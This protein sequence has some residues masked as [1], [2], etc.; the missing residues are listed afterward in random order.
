MQQELFDMEVE[1][2]VSNIDP[3]FS[4]VAD[5]DKVDND[6]K[7]GDAVSG[8]GGS[9]VD[10]AND[11]NRKRM[12]AV[13]VYT[14]QRS[15][16]WQLRQGSRKLNDSLVVTFSQ[17]IAYRV[18]DAAYVVPDLESIVKEPF[19]NISKRIKY[20][21][22][23]KAQGNGTFNDLKR[24]TLPVIQKDDPNPGDSPK[25]LD[26]LMIVISVLGGILV[27]F[28]AGLIFLRSK[29]QKISRF[30]HPQIDLPDVPDSGTL[31]TDPNGG[32]MSP[33]S[34]ADYPGG[35][36]SVVTIDH[37]Y[38]GQYNPGPP[39]S[40]GGTIGSAT[41]HSRYSGADSILTPGNTVG[42][43][44]I[45]TDDASFEAHLRGAN[46]PITKEDIFDVIAPPGKLG[47]VIDT[48]NSGAPVVYNIKENCP[49]ADQLMEGDKVIYVDDE[50]VRNLTA[51][52]VSRLISE[53]SANP[54]RKFTIMRSSIDG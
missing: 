35:Q 43:Q 19:N 34:I 39:S 42:T 21:D 40:S 28:V 25:D 32:V 26:V 23:L 41:R 3:P 44:S 53:K 15:T 46:Q 31:Q 14:Q 16:K 24:A 47:V 30:P 36:Q 6:G 17:T 9:S 49:I 33:E 50:D 1:I 18:H 10:G 54:E 13:R 51:V 22:F 52:Q 37:D 4:T 7:I 27:L 2:K 11:L 48:P 38:Q 12:L 5:T 29:S 8:D 45:Y 20:V